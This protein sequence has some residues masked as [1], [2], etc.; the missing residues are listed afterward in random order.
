[1]AAVCKFKNFEKI[2]NIYFD[3]TSISKANV[4]EDI[5][6]QMRVRENRD[7]DITALDPKTKNQYDDT[8]TV[9][10]DTKLFSLQQL[11]LEEDLEEKRKQQEWKHREA[12]LQEEIE[13]LKREWKRLEAELQK[14]IEQFKSTALS[15]KRIN[16]TKM[17][18][19]NYSPS[20]W[21]KVPLRQSEPVSTLPVCRRCHKP[22]HW[23]HQC[24]FTINRRSASF[25]KSYRIPRT[26]MKIVN[27][28]EVPGAM[29]T[30][31]GKFDIYTSLSLS[32]S[33]AS[34]QN[35][36]KQRSL[37]A[38]FWTAIVLLLILFQEILL[39]YILNIFNK[40]NCY[41]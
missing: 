11:M 41:N 30:T 32:T 27:G 36:K 13:Q 21:L 39:L 23:V 33:S 9:S 28:P 34:S 7:G 5:C 20:K 10:C 18:K 22:G 4:K 16:L 3:E 24:T 37:S 6:C 26:M 38:I 2:Y 35:I 29:F 25:K 15:W 31:T 1:M 12:K 8:D 14:K 19:T 17:K 40:K